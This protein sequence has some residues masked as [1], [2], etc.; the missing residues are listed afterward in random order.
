M[1][2]RRKSVIVVEDEISIR[3]LL[4]S[5]LELHKYDH[6]A[7][8]TAEEALEKLLHINPDLALIDYCLPSMNGL[9][10]TEKLEKSHP[11][12]PVILMSGFNLEKESI[13][14]KY[15]SVCDIIDKPFEIEAIV[16]KIKKGLGD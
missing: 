8:C 14:R 9:T 4:G 7:F 6:I 12:L 1:Q 13:R 3:E 10:L 16:R 11:G 2:E 15:A 5:I